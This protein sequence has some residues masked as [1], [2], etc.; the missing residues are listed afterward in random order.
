MKY[1]I[2]TNIIVSAA[3][4]PGSVPDQAFM[5]AATPKFHSVICEYSMDEMRR[6]FNEKFPD[7]I[8]DYESFVSKI[9]FSLTIVPTPPEESSTADEYKIRDIKDRPILRAAIAADMD[10]IITGDKDFLEAKIEKPKMIT[11]AQFVN[12][13]EFAR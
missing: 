4:F 5:K 12:L 6:I 13:K 7:R 11:A 3:L 9:V 2:D 8:P 1:L 10:G